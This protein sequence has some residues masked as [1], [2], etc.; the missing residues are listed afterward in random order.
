MRA[1]RW[2]ERS[3]SSRSLITGNVRTDESRKEMRNNPGAPSPPANATIFCFHPLRFAGKLSILRQK[4]LESTRGRRS[5]WRQHSAA[6]RTV[7]RP[8]NHFLNRPRQARQI[9]RLDHER[10]RQVDDITKRL[11]PASLF[12]KSRA[13]FQLHPTGRSICTTPTAPFTRTSARL[14][15]PAASPVPLS[16]A[17]QSPPLAA[18]AARSRTDRAK[19]SP[20]HN[21]A[22]YAMYVGPCISAASGSSDKKPSYTRSLATVAASGIVP[23]VNAF[24]RQIMSGTTPACSH[25]NIVPVRPNPVKISSKISSKPC[26]SHNAL[27]ITQHFW[28]RETSSRQ[29]PESAAR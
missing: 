21:P 15:L 23:P 20:P 14:A 3:I 9:L 19:H 13:Q 16:T 1:G 11:D 28:R 5:K 29:R 18:A 6:R 2:M 25:A 24:D 8:F 4:V 12:H 17:P 26:R 27:Q 22:G 7:Y 10:R